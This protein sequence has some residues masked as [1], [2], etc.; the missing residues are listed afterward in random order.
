MGREGEQHS[1]M[2]NRMMEAEA[3][4]GLRQAQHH[5]W[6]AALAQSLLAHP[7]LL[8]GLGA[9]LAGFGAAALV[10]FQVRRLRLVGISDVVLQLFLSF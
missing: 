7:A 6:M 8:F 1:R 10:L 3:S 5:C 9:A 4:A 2:L